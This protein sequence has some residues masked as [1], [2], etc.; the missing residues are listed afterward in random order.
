[1]RKD[2]PL[3]LLLAIG[4]FACNKFDTPIEDD[5]NPE[6]QNHK[7]PYYYYYKGNKQYLHLNTEYFFAST[8]TNARLSLSPDLPVT[9][10]LQKK[11]YLSGKMKKQFRTNVDYSWA[12]YKLISPQSELDY[13]TLLQRVKQDENVEVVSPFFKTDVGETIGLSN[14]FYVRLKSEQD[15]EILKKMSEQ[16]NVVIIEQNQFMP[17]WYTLSCTKE[18]QLNA[19]QMANVYYESGKFSCSEPDLMVNNILSCASDA[20]WSNQWGFLNTG[21]YNGTP[22]ID[23]KA[24]DAWAV[25]KGSGIKVAVIDQ[26]IELT[27]EDLAANIYP[28]SYDVPTNSSPSQIRGNH[29]TACAG[30]IGAND[31]SIGITGIAPDCQLMSVSCDLSAINTTVAAGLANGINWARTNG[32]DVISN[33]WQLPGISSSLLTD[34]INNALTLGR[35]GKGCV[36]VFASGNHAGGLGPEINFPANSNLDILVVGMISP[37][38]ERVSLASC[39]TEGI[40]SNYG[41]T[42]DVMAPGIKIATTDLTG[43]SG[44]ESGNYELEFGGT[45][46]A[47]PTVAGIAALILS[48]NPDLTALQVRNIIEKSSEKVGSYTYSTTSGRPNGTWNEEMG[49]GL[50]SAR[51]AVL[52]TISIDP[53]TTDIE[54]RFYKNVFDGKKYIGMRGKYREIGWLSMDPT[55]NTSATFSYI[56]INSTPPSSLLGGSFPNTILVPTEFGWDDPLLLETAYLYETSTGKWYIGEFKYYNANPTGNLSEPLQLDFTEMTTITSSQYNIQNV[57]SSTAIGILYVSSTT[58]PTGYDPYPWLNP[59]TV[60]TLV[61]GNTIQ[62]SSIAQNPGLYDK[63]IYLNKLANLPGH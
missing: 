49:Y 57:T 48:L 31:N 30:I 46:S 45:S 35:G 23:V 6:K 42:L 61:N 47:C 55:F 17:L 39:Q 9:Q 63:T 40:K 43:S 59:I 28:S 50:V 36:V 32:A 26:G 24:C 41:S 21:Q 15:V 13:F 27:H 37:C 44:Y 14:F 5:I 33:S 3:L 56:N 34:A 11:E 20:L 51:K 22:G 60:N 52:S 8:R 12:Q 10:A 29:G 18:S 16:Y 2:F 54:G 1:M 38:G 19:M 53:P 58:S 62:F 7:T 4:F 25:S